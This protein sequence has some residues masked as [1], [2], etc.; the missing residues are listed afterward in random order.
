MS[1]LDLSLSRIKRHSIVVRCWLQ[2]GMAV[3]VKMS[4]I[5]RQSVTTAALVCSSKAVSGL[6]HSQS[7]FNSQAQIMR[8]QS[9]LSTELLKAV[10]QHSECF[11]PLVAPFYWSKQLEQQQLSDFPKAL[12]LWQTLWFPDEPRWF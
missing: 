9:N 8:S 12:V 7:G 4:Y 3:R 2:L 11:S 1:Q 6:L 5:D 10:A